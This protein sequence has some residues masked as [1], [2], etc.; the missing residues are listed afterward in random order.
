MAKRIIVITGAN[1]GLGFATAQ[2]LAE[3]GDFVILTARKKDALEK[4]VSQLKGQSLE[5]EGKEVDVANP[6]Q[7]KELASWIDSQ[8]GR[9]D[10]L[11]NNAGVTLE[12]DSGILT[13][14]PEVVMQTYRINTM[15][16]LHMAQALVPLLKKSERGR[17]VNLSSGMG[18]LTDMGSGWSGYR[19]S[20]TSLNVLTILLANELRQTNIKVNAVCPGWVRTDMGGPNATLSIEDGI[21]GILWATNLDDN[22][23]T[24]GF[25]RHGK[26]IDW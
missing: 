21:Q 25:F 14:D 10:I 20:K 1:R 5:V 7:V 8:Y 18:A 23:P 26:P 3:G 24:G 19:F 13:V 15:G 2:T 16:P 4:A 17:I 11:I 6:E 22:G 12:N 9:L